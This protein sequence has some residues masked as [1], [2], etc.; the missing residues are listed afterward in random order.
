MC[1]IATLNL[2]ATAAIARLI[3]ACHFSFYQ[4]LFVNFERCNS[5]TFPIYINQLED[6]LH[7]IQNNC[8]VLNV[9]G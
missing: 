2:R 8:R 4:N 9:V 5:E 6:N 3:Y 7:L 1:L